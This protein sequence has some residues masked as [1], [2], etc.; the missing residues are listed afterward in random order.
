V[1]V[2]VVVVVD[3]DDDQA[4][5]LKENMSLIVLPMIRIALGHVFLLVM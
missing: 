3:D 4:D 1:A 2:G 5:N